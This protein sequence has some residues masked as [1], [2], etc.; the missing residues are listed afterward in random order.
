MK[1]IALP[2]AGIETLYGARDAN[3][4]HIESL[5]NVDIRTQGSE[6]TVE[7]EPAAEQRAAR[8]RTRTRTGVR[9]RG[10]FSCSGSFSSNGR[11]HRP[12][13]NTSLL[14]A[15]AQAMWSP[16]LMAIVGGRSSGAGCVD[17]STP[18]RPSCPSSL[19]PQHHTRPSL[20][21]EPDDGFMFLAYTGQP[22]SPDLLTRWVA[23]YVDAAN[24]G[25]RGSCHLFRH[26]VA[27]LMLERGADIRYVQEM[28]G[29]ASIETT[30]FYTK[31]SIRQLK[32]I[33]AATHPAA[34]LERSTPFRVTSD[35]ES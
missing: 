26:S 34:K 29:H 12:Q 10:A 15:T 7:G 16:T 22:F 23:E 9:A 25:K 21:S 19:L 24:I 18:P 27:T 4:K 32:E 5:L 33:H 1:K 11:G 8:Q 17:P 2:E 6:L 28:L 31:V 35:D 13:Q 14:S 3:L 20:V 30:Q